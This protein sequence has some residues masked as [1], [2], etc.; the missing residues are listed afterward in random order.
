M[1]EEAGEGGVGLGETRTEMPA[2]AAA[3]AAPAGAMGTRTAGAANNSKN[4]ALWTTT[5]LTRIDLSRHQICDDGAVA[6]ALALSQNVRVKVSKEN[7][8]MERSV[9]RLFT[10]LPYMM[11]AIASATVSREQEKGV[12]GVGEGLAAVTAERDDPNNSHLHRPCISKN[13]RTIESG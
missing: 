13:T 8:E 11:R 12:P 4:E 10:C 7:T 9:N 6:L 3:A 5:P 1:V 2:T